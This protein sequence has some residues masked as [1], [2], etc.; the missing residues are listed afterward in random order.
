M[1]KPDKPPMSLV[2]SNSRLWAYYP[3][4][5]PY[6]R[7]GHGPATIG[8]DAA[9]VQWEVWEA[10]THRCVGVH[11]YLSSALNQAIALTQRFYETGELADE[12]EVAVANHTQADTSRG[13]TY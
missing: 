5:I 1:S 3:I 8:V 13:G 6:T 4:M 12:I 2:P 7:N 9:T 10:D 11:D